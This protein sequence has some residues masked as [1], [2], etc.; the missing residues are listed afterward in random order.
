LE[1]PQSSVSIHGYI[2]SRPPWGSRGFA[3]TRGLAQLAPENAVEVDSPGTSETVRDAQT[4][5]GAKEKRVGSKRVSAESTVGDHDRDSDLT[6]EETK[7]ELSRVKAELERVKAEQLLAEQERE[8]QHRKEEMFRRAPG[9]FSETAR[10]ITRGVDTMINFLISMPA[11]FKCLFSMSRADWSRVTKTNWGHFKHEMQHYWLGTKL[12][13]VEVQITSRLV[14]QAMQGKELTR[15]E[16]KQLVRTTN[17]LLRIVPFAMFIIIPF[18]ELLLPVALKL[19]PNMLPSTFQDNLKKEEE[20]RKRV[21]AKMEV[22]RFLQDCLEEKAKKLKK[23][24]TGDRGAKGADLYN[25]LTKVRQGQDVSN[26]EFVRFAGL[27][28]DELTLDNLGR[29]QLVAMCRFLQLSTFGTDAVLRYSLRKRLQAIKAD[30]R[31]IKAEGLSTLTYEEL[32]SACQARGLRWSGETVFGMRR[33]IVDWLDLSLH[34][35]LPSSLLI[36]SRAMAYTNTS[37]RFDERA[38]FED[39]K[40]TLTELP[41]VVGGVLD[42]AVESKSSRESTLGKL[43]YLKQQDELIRAEAQEAERLHQQVCALEAQECTPKLAANPQPQE[44][45]HPASPS[46]TEMDATDSALEEMRKA[47]AE[48]ETSLTQP[49]SSATTEAAVVPKED[50]PGGA[51]PVP[52]SEESVPDEE[53]QKCAK[54]S[55][56]AAAEKKRLKQVKELAVALSVLSNKS[57]VGDM[58]EEL[59]ALMQKEVDYYEDQISESQ[60]KA[61]EQAKEQLQEMEEKYIEDDTLRNKVDDLLQKLDREM[62]T[63]DMTVGSRLKLLDRDND[64]LLSL[65]E[66]ANVSDLLRDDKLKGRVKFILMDLI[67]GEG[68]IHVD[69]I[70]RLVEHCDQQSKDGEG[71]CDES[72]S[73]ETEQGHNEESK[74]LTSEE[75]NT[76]AKEVTQ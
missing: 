50:A 32:R 31:M 56:A 49:D 23:S 48:S 11:W 35:N 10:T 74:L 9:F 7:V 15:R 60:T 14:Y 65:D 62:D 8:K 30:D 13:A 72:D 29:T 64:G 44:T 37:R 45:T 20:Q 76:P 47:T 67:D 68:N 27:F 46:R 24:K 57:V 40:S 39:V 4:A 28:S 69:D 36:L 75:R 6:S 16:R 22:A 41:G 26:A 53:E 12:L 61:L 58:R 18:M 51:P 33:Q 54:E 25:L 52:V 70:I 38:V 2:P 73:A 43:D 42:M 1:L 66:L 55:V 34:H 19:F 17:D 3:V 5:Q 21:Q 71:S 59:N 63:V